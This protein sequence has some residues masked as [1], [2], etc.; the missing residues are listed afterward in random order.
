MCSCLAACRWLREVS[1]RGPCKACIPKL[2][3]S[4]GLH[5]CMTRSQ[6]L[7]FRKQPCI[8]HIRQYG[9]TRHRACIEPECASTYI[10]YGSLTHVLSCAPWPFRRIVVLQ[11]PARL[12]CQP[13]PLVIHVMQPTVLLKLFFCFD[14]ARPQMAGRRRGI[15]THRPRILDWLQLSRSRSSSLLCSYMCC[16]SGSGAFRGQVIE[17]SRPSQ[18]SQAQPGPRL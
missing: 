15:Q 11:G 13:Q 8:Y 18:P 1:R 14:E 17:G 12:S 5:F 7:G 16:C 6:A 10:C 3:S 4:P 2:S 9:R